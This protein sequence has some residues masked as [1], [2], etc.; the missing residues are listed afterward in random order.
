MSRYSWNIIKSKELTQSRTY[1]PLIALGIDGATVTFPEGW[2]ESVFNHCLKQPGGKW[3]SPVFTNLHEFSIYVK[4]SL[5]KKFGNSSLATFL[6]KCDHKA[7]LHLPSEI[8]ETILYDFAYVEGFLECIIKETKSKYFGNN[9][10][11]IITEAGSA[12]AGSAEAGAE[13][14]AA[15][16]GSAGAETKAGAEAEAAE[17]AKALEFVEAAKANRDAK[18]ARAPRTAKAPRAANLHSPEGGTTGT[19][20]PSRTENIRIQQLREMGYNETQINLARGV[21]SKNPSATIDALI[22]TMLGGKR[23][24]RTRRK[25][26]RKNKK[27]LKRRLKK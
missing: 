4:G 21:I 14:E 23:S 17:F 20:Q 10:T 11:A 5:I 1:G 13:T 2:E 26:Q 9:I 24:K 3:C 16:T 15:G 25:S 8:Q 18:A 19:T 22:E 12:E 27:T 7:S 6:T